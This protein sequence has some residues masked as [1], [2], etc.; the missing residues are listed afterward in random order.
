M[1]NLSTFNI[2][3]YSAKQKT[4]TPE[5]SISLFPEGCHQVLLAHESPQDTKIPF[6][7]MHTLSYIE[8]LTSEALQTAL[9][10]LTIR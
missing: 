3:L 8:D 4:R 5:V 7:P 1:A 10:S 6:K 9:V 2:P